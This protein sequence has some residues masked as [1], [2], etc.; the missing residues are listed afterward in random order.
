MGLVPF[1]GWDYDLAVAEQRRMAAQVVERG[2]LEGLRRVAGLDMALGRDG[3]TCVGA[4][5]VWDCKERRVLER[6][7]VWRR[8][9]FPYIPGFLSFRE[10]PVLVEALERVS[11]RVDVLM[12]DGQGR[13]H[14]RR[15]GLASHLGVLL[16]CVAVGCAKSLLVGSHDV[17]GEL[18][19]SKA[20]L[21]EREEVI[22]CVV[23]TRD[24]VRPV[25]VSV[26]HRISL[27]AATELVLL[28]G[29]GR[30][31]PEPTRLADQLSKEARR[32]GSGWRPAG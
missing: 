14:P 20:E 16:D 32:M 10:V 30:R 13:A 6:R 5:V 23:R 8:L 4:V 11:Y 28:C 12:C 21:V 24:R 31:I 2:G 9:E 26:G 3:T 18:R 27:L 1:E 19:G 22:G 15:L 7:V 29:E 25:Y 17:L